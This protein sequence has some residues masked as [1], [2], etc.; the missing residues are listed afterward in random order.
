M[1][2][3]R[4]VALAEDLDKTKDRLRQDRGLATEIEERIR[5]ACLPPPPMPLET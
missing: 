4:G 3:Y 2:H 5:Q 1:Y